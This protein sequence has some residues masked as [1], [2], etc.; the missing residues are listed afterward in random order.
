MSFRFHMKVR[1]SINQTVV[2]SLNPNKA[3]ID[4]DEYVVKPKLV[5]SA[6]SKEI[7][8][9]ETSNTNGNLEQLYMPD[10]IVKIPIRS[11]FSHDIK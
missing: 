4:I 2:T 6:I 1:H 3:V 8:V 10:E 5:N 9:V 7:P 11:I